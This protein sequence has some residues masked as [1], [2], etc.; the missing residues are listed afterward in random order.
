[1]G[2]CVADE[3]ADAA[4]GDASDSGAAPMDSGVAADAGATMDA[5][6]D[7]RTPVYYDGNRGCACRASGPARADRPAIAWALLAALAIAR[8]SRSARR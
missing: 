7:A 8:R 1:M 5:A 4:S 2:A 3:R 6:A